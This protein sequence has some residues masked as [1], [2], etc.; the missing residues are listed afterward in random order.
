MAEERKMTDMRAQAEA[1]DADIAARMN[2]IL[3]MPE[4]KKGKSRSKP[5]SVD[6]LKSKPAAKPVAKTDTARSK[7]RTRKPG[8][9]PRPPKGSDESWELAARHIAK[10]QADENTSE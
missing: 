7:S 1:A 2:E 10:Q 5:A 3:K 4:P 8:V 6:W 9:Q